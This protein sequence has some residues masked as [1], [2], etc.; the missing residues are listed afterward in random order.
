MAAPTAP[1]I[2]VRRAADRFQ[3]RAGWLDSSHSFSFGHHRDPRNTNHGLLLV[4]N[5]D[6]VAPYT[7]F[8]T[9]PHQDME[10]ITW[11]LEGRLEHKDTLGN[12]GEIFPGLAQRM[13]AGRGIWHSEKNNGDDTVHFVQMWVLPDSSGIDPGY[14]QLDINGELERG[15]LVPIAS[16]KGHDAAIGIAQRDAVLWGGRLKAGEVVRIPEDRHVHLFVARGAAELE[17]AGALAEGDAV[18]LT[19]AG[20]PALTAGPDG[21][22]V[23]VWATA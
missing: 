17:G 4:S 7:G 13:S 8:D 15:G 10:I 14:E 21:A 9:H 23:L 11:V 19:A 20:D 3:T 12:K 6:R 1:T 2:D 18:R 5:D 16:G 22:E